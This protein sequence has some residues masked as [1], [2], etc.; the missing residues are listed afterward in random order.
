MPEGDTIFRAARSL[1]AALAGGTITRF[2]TGYAHL[3]VVDDQSPIAG[4]TMLR[5]ESRGKHLLMW[6]SGDLVLR[7]HMRMSGSW[8][9]YRRGERW[10]RSP[11][12]MRLLLETARFVAV[13]FDVPDAEFLTPGALAR[14]RAVTSLGPDLLHDGFDRVDA[15][16]RFRQQPHRE[17]GVAL[18][19]Q[20]VMA[21]VGNVFK[22]EVLFATGVNPFTPVARLSDDVLLA[23]ID[24]SRK[25][26]RANVLPTSGDA[27]VTY[28]GQRRTTGQADPAARAWVSE[29]EGRPCR[30]CGR[31]I[32]RRKQGEDARTTYWCPACQP[33]IA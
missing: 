22:S 16:R 2:E 33:H 9:L 12:R 25:F 15:L 23:I 5:V 17:I 3:S 11:A 13:G 32:E 1:H 27:I 24:T 14:A 7:T 10:Q 28:T 6:M 31:A 30:R 18:L 19:D 26:L 21:G 29:R 4:R 20:R 8:H